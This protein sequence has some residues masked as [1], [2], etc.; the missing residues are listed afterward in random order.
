MDIASDKKLMRN[1]I[2]CFTETQIQQAQID[3]DDLNLIVN[4]FNIYFNNNQNKFMSLVYG[5]HNTITVTE[6]QDFNKL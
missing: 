6:K 5:L 1:H 3:K 2:L 4:G